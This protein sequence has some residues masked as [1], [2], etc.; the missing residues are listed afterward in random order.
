MIRIVVGDLA[1]QRVDAVVRAIRSDLAPVNALSRDLALAGGALLEERLRRLGGVPLGGAVLTPAGDLPADFVIHV[2]V[3]SEE[4]PQT[5]LTVQRAV[6]NALR[7]AAD[8][9]LESLAIPPL[10]IGVGTLEPDDAARAL[11][12]ILF[13]HLDEG[14]KPL[15]LTVVVATEYE[16]GLFARLVDE[17]SRD[18]MR[19]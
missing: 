10:G 11:L 5:P 3:M 16:E 12:E 2:V 18:R 9:G 14:Q 4:E 6:R 7:R 19:S 1:E 8:W 13:A 15:A 17:L